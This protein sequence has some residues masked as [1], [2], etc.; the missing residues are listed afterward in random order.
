MFVRLNGPQSGPGTAG[1][2][3]DAAT[4]EY[5]DLLDVIR[6][7]CGLTQFRDVADEARRFLSLP[8]AE[9]CRTP[10]PVRPP[11]PP[12]RRKRRSG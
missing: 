8:R 2:W 6:E 7:S 4:A 10:K 11:V 9:P 3:S 12:D 5:G 1:R